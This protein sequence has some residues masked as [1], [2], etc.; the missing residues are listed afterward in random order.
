MSDVRNYVQFSYQKIELF[1]AP[2]CLKEYVYCPEHDEKYL[3]SKGCKKVFIGC[4]PDEIHALQNALK[5]ER[6]QCGIK[7]HVTATIHGCQGDTLH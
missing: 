6:R 1:V 4:I 3:E 5:G 7:H 2:S